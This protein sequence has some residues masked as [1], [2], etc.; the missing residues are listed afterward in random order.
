MKIFIILLLLTSC[1]VKKPI[2][3]TSVKVI[4]PGDPDTENYESD[5][6][7]YNVYNVTYKRTGIT[8]L[9][10]LGLSLNIN[11]WLYEDVEKIDTLQSNVRLIEVENLNR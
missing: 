8:Q 3:N 1:A 4:L 10:V 7:H 11:E 5:T 6:S 2:D 9:F